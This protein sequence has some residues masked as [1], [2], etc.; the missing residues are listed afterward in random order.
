MH[1]DRRE[2]IGWSSRLSAAGDWGRY[3]AQVVTEGT[4]E[5]SSKT[6]ALIFDPHKLQPCEF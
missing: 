2:V 4:A 5:D 1:T 6:Y 3:A